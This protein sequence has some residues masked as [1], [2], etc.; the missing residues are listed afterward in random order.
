MIK[1][2]NMVEYQWLCRSELMCNCPIF[3]ANF[4]SSVLFCYITSYWRY[5]NI[6]EI[7]DVINAIENNFDCLVIILQ[8]P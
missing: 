4:I 1:Y 2:Y 3:I 7:V 5:I 8:Y 6:Q